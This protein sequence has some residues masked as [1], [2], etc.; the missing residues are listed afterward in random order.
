M[1][2]LTPTR[3]E[4][5][6]ARAWRDELYYESLTEEERASLPAHPAGELDLATDLK[7]LTMMPS[8]CL[9]DGVTTECTCLIVQRTATCT[10]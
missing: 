6:I 2:A 8:L 1:P 3:S 5:D 10:N 9:S 7:S 4:V